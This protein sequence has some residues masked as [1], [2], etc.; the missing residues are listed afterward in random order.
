MGS[1]GFLVRPA[2]REQFVFVASPFPEKRIG[3]SFTFT[4]HQKKAQTQMEA[5]VFK[6]G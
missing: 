3:F 5:F 4:W 2:D 6:F 1:N